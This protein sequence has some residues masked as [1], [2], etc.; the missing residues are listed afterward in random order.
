VSATAH[1]PR[2]LVIEDDEHVVAMLVELLRQEG[3]EATTAGDGL[4]GLLAL[5]DSEVEAVLLDLMMPDVD[6]VRVLE[7][8]LEEHD[9]VLPV[10]ILV[11]T[12]SPDGARR[13][14]DLLGDDD[15]FTK[16]FEPA[17]LIARLRARLA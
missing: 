9:G 5:Q 15:V 4:A 1:R 17:A 13:C 14:R 8:V 16:P 7:Q 11:V 2:V 6:G 12:G 3:F 10:P